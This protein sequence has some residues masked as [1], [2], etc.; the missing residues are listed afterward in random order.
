MEARHITY[1]FALAA[2]LSS[3]STNQ[4]LVSLQ[5]YD[6]LYFMP[7]PELSASNGSNF[8]P[9]S[10][11]PTFDGASAAEQ[12]YYSNKPYTPAPEPSNGA[13]E[14]AP[15][16]QN[17]EFDYYDEDY[18]KR[19]ENFHRSENEAYQYNPV[20]NTSPQVNWNVGVGMSNFGPTSSFGMGVGF[21][22][23]GFNNFGG[24]PPFYS[25]MMFN[26]GM[27]FCNRCMDPW[28]LSRMYA[29]DPFYNRAY[30]WCCSPFGGGM[31]FGSNVGWCASVGFGWGMSPWG[32]SPWGMSPWM[33]PP[34]YYDPWGFNNPNFFWGPD[35]SNSPNSRVTNTPRSE[36]TRPSRGG[37]VSTGSGIADENTGRTRSEEVAEDT[38]Q[39]TR[40][41]VSEA[42]EATLNRTRTSEL[43]DP[44]SEIRPRETRE[45]VGNLSTIPNNSS[46]F[47]GNDGNS[48]SRGQ[49]ISPY[50]RQR[51][52]MRNGVDVN[53]SR[54]NSNYF[55]QPTNSSPSPFNRS[56]NSDFN[57]GGSSPA[58]SP[59]RGGGGS[60][61]SVPTRRR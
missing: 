10:S 42:T 20:Q 34:Y 24:F 41:R 19:I 28:M 45:R 38:R 7:G 1:L 25:S 23:P 27:G 13:E 43:R 5:E 15:T 36:S 17:D 32:M 44:N 53:R 56:I 26:R 4:D 30:D 55:R 39:L 35:F 11:S 18:G 61:P 3:C 22:T 60:S 31:G 29:W 16:K 2:M 51:E 46:Y 48:R 47:R 50:S 14:P 37:V 40:Q 33:M 6:D 9:I 12:S 58:F 54:S 59:S 21:G 52:Q 8:T 49:N 57:R